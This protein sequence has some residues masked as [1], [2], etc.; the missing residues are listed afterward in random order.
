MSSLNAVPTPDICSS[1][2]PSPRFDESSDDLGDILERIE[3][4]HDRYPSMG[5]GDGR[6]EKQEGVRKSSATTTPNANPQL[7][8][9][10]CHKEFKSRKDLFTHLRMPGHAQSQTVKMGQGEASPPPAESRSPDATQETEEEDAP[11]LSAKKK[12]WWTLTYSRC[13]KRFEHHKRVHAHLAITHH[14]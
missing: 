4:E 11:R 2:T 1:I 3:P 5:K 7:T 9:S 13:N 12:E 14:Y 8:C 10:T 6:E